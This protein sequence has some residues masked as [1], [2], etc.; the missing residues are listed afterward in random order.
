MALLDCLL[1]D[2]LPQARELGRRWLRQSA[3]LWTRDQSWVLVFL[4]FPDAE[5]AAL[6]AELAADRLRDDPEMR[7]ALAV[8]L[9]ARLR[10]P[11]P[12]PGAD[13]VYA[14]VVRQALAEEMGALLSVPDLVAMV[15]TGTPPVQAMAGDLLGRRPEAVA[16]LGLEGLAAMAGHE[17]AAVRAAAQ[18][19][20]RG[21]ADAFHADPAPLFL[22][23]E[24]DWPD[25]R[26][27]AFELIR[28]QIDSE[29]LGPD[30]MIGL[31][32]SNRPD[33]QDFAREVV[34]RNI[35]TV[36]A[37]PCWSPAWSSTRTRTCGGSR[38]TW[39]SSTCP[40]GATRSPG[41]NGSS[42]R[43]CSTSGPIGW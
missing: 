32:D 39:R 31:L 43:R 29:T 21:A 17:V 20:M 5:T 26:A 11:E 36:E 13:D 16:F 6:S 14:R 15:T 8:R 18:A 19:L 27:V 41:S 28:H 42:A 35:A 24:S 12:A 10:A 22:L 38:S 34:K 40:T 25:T 37:A 33:V 4:G 1:S 7:R 23:V 3:P 30:A 9:L 2:E